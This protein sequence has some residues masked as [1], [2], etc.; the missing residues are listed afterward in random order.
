MMQ[1]PVQP[2]YSVKSTSIIFQSNCSPQSGRH[3]RPLCSHDLVRSAANSLT[4][5]NNFYI[6]AILETLITMRGLREFKHRSCASSLH[7]YLTPMG[8]GAYRS[9]EG[10]NSH[11]S[12]LLVCC[13]S[14]DVT[15]GYW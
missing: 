9:L 5:K 3:H 4:V 13:L 7:A 2:N 14:V 12:S 10:V 8:L 15:D 11:L 1:I 6:F